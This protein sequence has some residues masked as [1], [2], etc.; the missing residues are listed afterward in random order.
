MLTSALEFISVELIELSEYFLL[1]FCCDSSSSILYLHSQYANR[2]G[3]HLPKS[4]EYINQYYYRFFCSIFSAVS[5]LTL[6]MMR[7]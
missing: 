6:D 1:V 2:I 5:S 4:N 7:F 3:T